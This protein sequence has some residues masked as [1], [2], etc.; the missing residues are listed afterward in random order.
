MQ[1][2]IIDNI[3]QSGINPKGGSSWDCFYDTGQKLTIK[4]TAETAD[5][6]G[7]W[8][9]TQTLK[10]STRKATYDGDGTM[11][12][13]PKGG[14]PCLDGDENIIPWYNSACEGKNLNSIGDSI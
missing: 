9:L 2:E 11:T 6:Y 13:T 8:G 5:D 1:I 10:N 4:V 7:C 12:I 3:K 14:C